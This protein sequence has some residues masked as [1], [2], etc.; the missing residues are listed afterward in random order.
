MYCSALDQRRCTR[1]RGKKEPKEL[2]RRQTPLLH[3]GPHQV[4]KIVLP[5]CSLQRCREML[6]LWQ[7]HHPKPRC[8]SCCRGGLWSS[9]CSCSSWAA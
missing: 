5:P 7:R 9:P 6:P 8:W 1:N 3:Q 4:R 2:C